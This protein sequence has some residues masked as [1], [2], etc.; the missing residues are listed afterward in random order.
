MIKKKNFVSFRKRVWTLLEPAEEEKP[1]S[2]ADVEESVHCRGVG[3][4]QH[5]RGIVP[6]PGTRHPGDRGR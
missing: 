5:R 2:A 6:R 1:A 4:A 3:R